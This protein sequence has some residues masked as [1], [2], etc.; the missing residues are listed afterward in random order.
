MPYKWAVHASIKCIYSANKAGDTKGIT[1]FM[2]NGM[3]DIAEI[4]AEDNAVM[5]PFSGAR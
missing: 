3:R 4:V 1:P 5:A 2:H